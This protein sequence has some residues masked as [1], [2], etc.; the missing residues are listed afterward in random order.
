VTHSTHVSARQKESVSVTGSSLEVPKLAGQE[1]GS[2][3]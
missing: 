2:V 1:A 3:T